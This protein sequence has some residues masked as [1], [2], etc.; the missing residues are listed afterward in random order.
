MF[1]KGAWV[2]RTK[3]KTVVPP[4]AHIKGPISCLLW[5]P[6]LSTV[7]VLERFNPSALL[8]LRVCKPVSGRSGSSESTTD[9][10]ESHCFHS[11]GYLPPEGD[12]QS[13]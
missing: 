13:N 1:W 11:V 10:R 2:S 5:V 9:K 4:V 7:H 3:E 12:Y 6:S 8:V